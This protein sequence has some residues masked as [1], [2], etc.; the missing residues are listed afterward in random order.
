MAEPTKKSPSIDEFLNAI[1]GGDRVKNI[2]HNKCVLCSKDA[3][4]QF[5]DT[6]SAKEFTISGMCQE[7]QDKVF[8]DYEGID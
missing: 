8:S 5:K 6:L 2:S 1:S 7:C 3:T 4:S